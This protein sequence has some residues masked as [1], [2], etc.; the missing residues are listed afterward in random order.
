MAYEKISSVTPQDV[1]AFLLER[2]AT[3][4]C[5]CC[6]RHALKIMAGDGATP[7]LVFV[8]NEGGMNPDSGTLPVA[9]VVCQNCGTL[10]MHALG[11]IIDWKRAT[12][13]QG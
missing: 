10:R 5:R 7:S 2:G 4:E 11:A 12:D 1:K 8:P 6:G 13:S 9:V 3:E